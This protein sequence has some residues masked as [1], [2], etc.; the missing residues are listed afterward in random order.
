MGNSFQNSGSAAGCTQASAGCI[1]LTSGND[2]T[3]WYNQVGIGLRFQQTFGAVDVKTYGFYETAGKENLTTTAYTG[4]APNGSAATL[5]Y[6]NLSFYKAGVA[7]TA[8]NL[9]LAAD[10][11]GGAVN[12][13]LA[14]KPTGGV[15]MNAL[16]T[17]L[18]YSNGP[19]TLGGQ[20]G[21]IDSQGAAQLTGTSQRHEYILALG[22][23]YKLAPGLQLV[24]EY[25][26]TNRHQGGWDFA[27]NA[28]GAG[29]TA[30]KVGLTRDAQAQSI[31]FATVLTW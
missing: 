26:Y 24:A 13:Q 9:T 20:F 18:T 10:Y 23:N 25:Q 19:I 3:R 17:G 21:V 2:P 1:S 29:A 5:R 12:G 16:L 4:P 31:V 30:T 11:I 8:M 7:V 22:G 6:D 14:M 27:N 28:A 15:N